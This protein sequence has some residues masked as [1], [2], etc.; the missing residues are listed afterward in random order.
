MSKHGRPVSKAKAKEILRH[1]EVRGHRL[2]KKQKGLFGAIAGG[3]P[4]RKFHRSP[5]V[6]DDTALSETPPRREYHAE[7]E[8]GSGSQPGA[9]G[10]PSA[11][12]TAEGTETLRTEVETRGPITGDRAK[13]SKNQR[14]Y[15]AG[16]DSYN[17]MGL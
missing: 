9:A 15:P 5:D 17:E 14:R 4:L 13:S 1:G 2:T 10:L 8:R 7:Q 16:M 6:Y 12:Q 11:V 3:S